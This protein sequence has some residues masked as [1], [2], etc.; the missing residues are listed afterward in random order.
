MYYMEVLDEIAALITSRRQQM[1]AI[2]TIPIEHANWRDRITRVIPGVRVMAYENM[3]RDVRPFLKVLEDGHLDAYD[4]IC[5]IHGKRSRD[6]G[7]AQFFGDLWRRR[8][9][10]D[11]L[12]NQ[13][14]LDRILEL[15]AHDPTIG[16][17]GPAAYRC[18]GP[19]FGEAVGWSAN[20]KRV[21]DL[22]ARMGISPSNHRLDFFAGTMFW[23]RRD[24]LAPLRRLALADS[25]FD[26][27]S[28][29]LDGGPEHAIERIFGTAVVAAGMRLQNAEILIPVRWSGCS[30][31]G[32]K[33]LSAG[34]SAHDAAIDDEMR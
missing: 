13:A 12:G 29:L 14:A 32:S 16:M 21:L 27:E 7:R 8:S 6:D 28:G 19:I 1:D 34:P 20:R 25:F 26:S 4:V 24:A 33:A 31:R 30:L 3:G 9:F 5:K 17:I 22:A 10:Y 11:L 15:F 23:V 2:V 18:P